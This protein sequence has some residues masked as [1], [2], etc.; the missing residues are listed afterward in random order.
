V[1]PGSDGAVASIRR[2]CRSRTDRLSVLV[3]GA[4]GGGGRGEAAW[5]RQLSV[6]L[7]TARAEAKAVRRR[8]ALSRE[9]FGRPRHIEIQVLGDGQ[10]RAIHR[11]ERDRSPQRAIGLGVKATPPSTRP[12]A[13]RGETVA[14]AMRAGS[15][16]GTVLYEDGRFYFIEMNTRIQVE[17][18]VTEMITEHRSRTRADWRCRRA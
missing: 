9:A 3:G 2:R 7:A 14:E 17:H 5:T 6:V 18:P 11:G 15:G 1:V 8:R 10:G 16:V 12:R 13:T 4:A